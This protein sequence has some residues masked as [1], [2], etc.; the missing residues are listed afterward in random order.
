MNAAWRAIPKRPA[1]SLRSFRWK[2][3]V[4][5]GVAVVAVVVSGNVPSA[6]SRLSDNVLTA[7]D[8]RQALIEMLELFP[9]GRDQKPGDPLYGKWIDPPPDFVLSDLR[10]GDSLVIV[11]DP[12][13]WSRLAG[14]DVNA[15]E[16]AVAGDANPDFYARGG[17]FGYE[18]KWICNLNRRTV[19]F[20]A[21]YRVWRYEMVGNFT[22]VDGKWRVEMQRRAIAH[23]GLNGQFKGSTIQ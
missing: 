1:L 21:V 14:G 16:V 4:L 15:L 23:Y 8:A 9:A 10:R 19:T 12:N 17:F 3:A 20:W 22:R 6:Q 13:P 5:A 7:A 11:V 2:T 18:W